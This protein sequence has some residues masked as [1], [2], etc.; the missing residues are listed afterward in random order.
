GED[1]GL[2]LAE[3]L[4][5]L[6]P[7]GAGNPPISLLVAAATLEDR[8]GFGGDDR[9]DHVR[10]NVRSGGARAR[11]VHFGGGAQLPVA[12][13]APVDATFRLERNEWQGVVEPRLLLREARTCE[14]AP[15]VIIGEE[16]TYLDR[17]F[18]VL[19]AT[20]LTVSVLPVYA[21][22]QYDFYCR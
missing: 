5:A 8:I 13:G 14:P 21:V 15:I 9:E 7:F 18:A 10:F 11:A 2:A 19:D 20:H 17:V 3:E 6:A 1:L 16:G 12:A 22:M 4:L